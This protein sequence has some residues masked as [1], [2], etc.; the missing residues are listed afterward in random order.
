MKQSIFV[1]VSLVLLLAF[2]ASAQVSIN[3][4]DGSNLPGSTY[5]GDTLTVQIME[6]G[7]PVGAG[8][9]VVFV[10][11][12]IK[13]N[14][15]YTTTDL[16]GRVKYKPLVNGRL[17][18]RVLDG[19]NTV[20]ETEVTVEDEPW[21]PVPTPTKK[22]S[23]SSGGGG[24]PLPDPTPTPTIIPTTV[25]DVPIQVDTPI[26][27]VDQEVI[28]IIDSKPVSPE[29]KSTPA[30]STIPGFGVIFAIAGI[31]GGAYVYYRRM[32]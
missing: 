3:A 25:D 27:V 7:T 11:A 4:S 21:V 29:P 10:H 9:V 24:G 2:G 30:E 12:N 15:I 23:S 28:D 13:G 17:S 19:T 20:A 14:P 22:V 16:D 1:V 31:L 32:R 8:T 26:P 5:C 18:V 6:D